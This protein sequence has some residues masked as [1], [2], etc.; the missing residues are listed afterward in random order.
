MTNEIFNMNTIGGRI[1]WLR[2]EVRKMTQV[3][4]AREL[5][6]KPPSL[7]GLESG[8]SK[9]PS[10]ETL[11]K[12]SAV[13]QANPEWIMKGKGDP[14]EWPIVAGDAEAEVVSGFRGLSEEAQKVVLATIRALK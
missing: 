1:Y 14:F 5:G 13:L 2:K 3:D 6:I 10:A 12:L 9:A 11:M 4:L 7:R 8:R